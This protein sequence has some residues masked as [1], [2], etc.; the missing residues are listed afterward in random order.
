MARVVYPAGTAIGVHAL[1][2]EQ[3]FTVLKGRAEFQVGREKK[4]V[5]AG[6]AVLIRPRTDFA[7]SILEDFEVLRFRDRGPGA[8]AGKTGGQGPSFFKWAEMNSD[9]ITPKYSS[10]TGPT[11]SGERIEVA[12]MNYPAGTEAKPHSHPNE[13]IQVPLKGKILGLG[14]PDVV[15]GPNEV[16]LIPINT[17]HGVRILEDYETVNCKNIVPGFSVYHARW[18]K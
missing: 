17:L 14:G 10:G 8:S 12:W 1:A 11:V 13:Q 15:S 18:E 2:N 5:G 3:I 16:I 6:E 4:T 7:A 9:F